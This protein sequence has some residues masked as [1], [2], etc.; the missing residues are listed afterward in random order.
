M[1][2]GTGPAISYADGVDRLQTHVVGESLTRQDQA[3]M[4]NINVI[5]AKTQRGEIVLARDVMPTFDDFSNELTYDVMLETIQEAEEAFMSLDATERKK[6]GNDPAN[7]YSS[8]LEEASVLLQEKE[9]AKANELKEAKKQKEIEKA[10]TLLEK[11]N[12]D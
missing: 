10:K 12:S 1:R 4:V 8:K 3:D 9:T 5:Y 11:Q 6:Y 7:Y 2:N